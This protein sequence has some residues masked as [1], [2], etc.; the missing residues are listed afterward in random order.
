VKGEF[1]NFHIPTPKPEIPLYH[2]VRPYQKPHPPIAVAGLHGWSETL[3]LAGERGWI[4]MSINFIPRRHLLSQ[5][6]AVE[7]GAQ[8]SGRTAD[9]RLWRV[10]RE[11]YVAETDEIARE[12]A[13]NSIMTQAFEGYLKPTLAE[14][15]FLDVYKA[16]PDMPDS[17]VTPEYLLDNIW[18]VGSPD[19]V[20]EKIR[21]LYDDLGGFNTLLMITHDFSPFERWTNCMELF[22]KEVMPNLRDLKVGAEAVA[23]PA[24]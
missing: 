1:W 9:R 15:N 20:T 24:D 16:D 3:M 7:A 12:Q 14:R 18:I 23:T 2:H 22:A 17:E 10:S 8:K 11:I 21:A 6:A 19:T 13:L 5:W 4:P